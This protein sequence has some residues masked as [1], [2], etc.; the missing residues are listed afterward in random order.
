MQVSKY[1]FNIFFALLILLS[2]SCSEE[3]NP[4]FDKNKNHFTGVTLSVP[5]GNAIS[6]ADSENIS[7]RES[8]VSAIYFFA[9]PIESTD[10]GEKVAERFVGD[11]PDRN[12]IGFL[13]EVTPTKVLTR[14]IELS[15]GNYRFYCVANYPGIDSSYES[16]SEDD[17]KKLIIS[18]PEHPILDIPE[19][20]LPMSCTPTGFNYK[21]S[22]GDMTPLSSGILSIEKGDNIELESI[23]Q[24]TVAKIRLN[25]INGSGTN[26]KISELM[27]SEISESVPLFPQNEYDYGIGF[28]SNLL[29]AASFG[30]YFPLDDPSR[31]EPIDIDRGID[32]KDIDRSI[33]GKEDVAEDES[34]T[35]HYQSVVYVPERILGDDSRNPTTLSIEVKYPDGSSR[36]D[37]KNIPLGGTPLAAGGIPENPKELLRSHLYQYTL[38]ISG[39]VEITFSADLEY[40]YPWEVRGIGM[41]AVGT[42]ELSVDKTRIGFGGKSGNP[43]DGQNPVKLYYTSDCKVSFE[44]EKHGDVDW[45]VLTPGVDLYGTYVEVSVNPAIEEEYEGKEI[46]FYIIADNIYKRIEVKANYIPFLRVSPGY[47]RIRIEDFRN[48]VGTD[49]QFYYVTNIADVD[50]SVSYAID[51]AD[52]LTAT[53]TDGLPEKE[54]DVIS[55][56]PNQGMEWNREGFNVV[57]LDNTHDMTKYTSNIVLRF[58]YTAGEKTQYSYLQI[59]PSGG[60]YVVH[61]R[62]VNTNSDGTGTWLK[63]HVYVYDHL[64]WFNAQTGEY[65]E[66]MCFEQNESR[67]DEWGNWYD[68]GKKLYE[69]AISISY[70][71]GITFKGWSNVP[72]VPIGN[73]NGHNFASVLYWENGKT[74]TIPTDYYTTDINYIGD[75]LER[76]ASKCSKCS[77]RDN[78]DKWPGV[79]MIQETGENESWWKIELPE[80]CT[81][82]KTLIMFSEGHAVAGQWEEFLRYP[83]HL[84]PGVPLFDYDDRE[85]WFLYDPYSQNRE[86]V[87]DKPNI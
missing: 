38:S 23:L 69:N 4:E 63:P 58:K 78:I 51:P 10:S 54:S 22:S 37:R 19:E 86:F 43:I 25:V 41:A 52:Y 40:E 14:D 8:T 20:G 7:D 72:T 28:D 55:F 56:F 66:I 33:G 44:S 49:T 13:S 15:P 64:D 68:T 27:L 77:A 53:Y 16:I 50:I 32:L 2:Q 61:L 62:A 30:K 71:G 73:R 59:I 1:Y 29:G 48:M 31:L 82:G 6:R 65:E 85:G 87:D 83:T 24:F 3:L 47:Q 34:S 70:T 79:V 76:A 84:T 39:E 45:L 67:Q 60:K 18:Y 80:I 12:T 46:A 21:S 42:R 9:F 81:P 36:L 35:W 26:L 74:E 17:L 75:H 11:S 57:A 5:I